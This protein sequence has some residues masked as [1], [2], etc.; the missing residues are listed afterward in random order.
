[1]QLVIIGSKREQNTPINL[2]KIKYYLGPHR[3]LSVTIALINTYGH[4]TDKGKS[5]ARRISKLVNQ[6]SFYIR[7][8]NGDVIKIIKPES[9]ST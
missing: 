1:M 9:P 2:M 8:H 3:T 6:L 7:V 5:L 4:K